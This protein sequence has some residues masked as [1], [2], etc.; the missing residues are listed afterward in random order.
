M[1]SEDFQT[2]KHQHRT[3]VWLKKKNHFG[4]CNATP[5]LAS[6]HA[7]TFTGWLSNALDRS[8]LWKKTTT[9]KQRRLS[10]VTRA[11]HLWSGSETW[12]PSHP[13]LEW[14]HEM[15]HTSGSNPSRFARLTYDDFAF[16]ASV[17]QFCFSRTYFHSL[18]YSFFIFVHVRL[19]DGSW[20]VGEL[21]TTLLSVRSDL[22]DLHLGE[23][24]L[25]PC[26]FLR[27]HWRFS[28]PG[29]LW[30]PSTRQVKAVLGAAE[31]KWLFKG[32]RHELS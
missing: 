13:Q 32:E 19:D 11:S 10:T 28:S 2:A 1:H 24:F 8:Q 6:L 27:R 7:Y 22:W 21:M 3:D 4:E 20:R 31:W 14:M 23:F 29:L 26:L 17:V 9:K 18:L 15:W 16:S 30:S 25:S 5:S 12:R